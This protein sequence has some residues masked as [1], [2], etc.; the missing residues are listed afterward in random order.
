MRHMEGRVKYF[1]DADLLISHLAKIVKVV[2]FVPLDQVAASDGFLSDILQL[3]EI[4]HRYRACITNRKWPLFDNT[5][6]R[7]PDA[8]GL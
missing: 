1:E 6:N 5:L 8:E 2:P 4:I 3:I 7:A